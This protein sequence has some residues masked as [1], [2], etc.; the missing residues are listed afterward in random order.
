VY[1]SAKLPLN[2]EYM[3]DNPGQCLHAAELELTHPRTGEKM[4]FSCPLPEYF[5]NVLQKLR[6]KN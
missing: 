1:G 2:R 6:N 5:T 3:R 4:H